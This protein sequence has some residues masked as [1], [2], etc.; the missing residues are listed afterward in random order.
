MTVKQYLARRSVAAVIAVAERV[1]VAWT[2]AMAVNTIAVWSVNVL[3]RAEPAPVAA[4]A[5][6]TKVV[7]IAPL[8]DGDLLV[9]G[10]PMRDERDAVYGSQHANDKHTLESPTEGQTP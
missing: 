3:F 2:A 7:A 8:S 4:P 6:D 5:D 1:D 10:P 9:L